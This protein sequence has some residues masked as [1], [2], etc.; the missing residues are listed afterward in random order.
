M[1]DI[2][3]F[4]VEMSI[5][6]F[7]KKKKYQS[8]KNIYSRYFIR[9]NLIQILETRYNS[10]YLSIVNFMTL[11]PS[12]HVIIP[13]TRRKYP[14]SPRQLEAGKD[15]ELFVPTGFSHSLETNTG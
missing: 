9:E 3:I 15:R 7:K 6:F 8:F 14:R 11:S 12:T 2:T 5:V 4:R 10:D 1:S 13:S